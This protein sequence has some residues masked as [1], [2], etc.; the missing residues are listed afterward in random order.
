MKIFL[1]MVNL[2]AKDIFCLSKFRIFT[3]LIRVVT[4]NGRDQFYSTRNNSDRVE[5]HNT[6]CY[7]NRSPA[8]I[9]QFSILLSGLNCKLLMLWVEGTAPLQATVTRGWINNISIVVEITLNPQ[10]YKLDFKIIHKEKWM[11]LMQDCINLYS[12]LNHWSFSVIKRLNKALSLS[13]CFFSKII[14]S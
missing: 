10:H 2:K 8:L 13:L 12:L 1:I 3:A 14:Y 11:N 7:Q 9:R 6:W 4:R 5:V